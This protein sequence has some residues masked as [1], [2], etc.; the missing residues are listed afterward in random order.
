MFFKSYTF[1]WWQIGIF[2]LALLTIGI[3]IGSYWSEFF[4]NYLVPLIIIA[5]IASLYIMVISF[6]QLK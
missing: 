2:K 3:A 5:V 4:K 6:K 1:T